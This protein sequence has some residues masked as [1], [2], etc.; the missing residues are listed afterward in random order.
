MRRNREAGRSCLDAPRLGTVVELPGELSVEIDSQVC[1][2][3]NVDAVDTMPGNAGRECTDRHRLTTT[4]PAD[5]DPDM[6]HRPIP[7]RPHDQVSR[8]RLAGDQS[9][10]LEPVVV[11][12][13]TAMLATD[14][15]YETGLEIGPINQP[16]TVV[17]P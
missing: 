15:P 16:R 8:S 17:A 13:G 7:A 5:E 10:V 1:L 3:G 2:E 14:L 9:V 4:V 11:A 6:G 12:A